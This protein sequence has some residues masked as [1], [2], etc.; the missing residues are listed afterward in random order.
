MAICWQ[1][2]GISARCVYIGGAAG[3]VSCKT[4]GETD[5][6]GI[7][8]EASFGT[9]FGQLRDRSG[10]SGTFRDNSGHLYGNMAAKVLT[11]QLI[12]CMMM[13]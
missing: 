12:A 3:P 11:F 9:V 13:V 10:Q 4:R 1:C 8:G 5:L 6:A 7:V 2:A